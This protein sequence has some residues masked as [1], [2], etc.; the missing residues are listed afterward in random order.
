MSAVVITAESLRM[1]AVSIQR[2]Q[3]NPARSSL[4]AFN[5]SIHPAYI[6]G[7]HIDRLIAALEVVER[8]EISRL[9]ITMPPHYSKSFNVSESFPAWCLGRNPDKRIIA[10]SHTAQLAYW[11]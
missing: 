6:G 8:G 2:K 11:V 7:A 4:M 10:S 5:R 3:A 1:A 9:I